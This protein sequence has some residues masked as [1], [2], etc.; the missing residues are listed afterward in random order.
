MAIG[1]ITGGVLYDF[2]SP[3]LPFLLMIAFVVPEFLII[4][5]FVHEPKKREQ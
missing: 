1:A 3:Q 2:V 4:L 5:R